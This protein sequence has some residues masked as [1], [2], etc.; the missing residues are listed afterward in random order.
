MRITSFTDRLK[1]MRPT[2]EGICISML[3]EMKIAA[4]YSKPVSWK[5]ISFC[6]II[7]QSLRW[8]S[9]TP[10]DNWGKNKIL[11][12]SWSDKGLLSVYKT[13]SPSLLTASI[14]KETVNIIPSRSNNERHNS[15]NTLRCYII[16]HQVPFSMMTLL[17]TISHPTAMHQSKS[18]KSEICYQL[19]SHHIGHS[20]LKC[21]FL[22]VQTSW[23]FHHR[24]SR[25]TSTEISP[26]IPA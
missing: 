13:Q 3:L 17:L 6:L 14:G 7:L 2:A 4:L 18:Y 20:L 26:G 25:A 22:D 9:L 15:V 10:T 16:R 19:K 21:P 24:K 5:V 1:D 12:F 11:Q 23:S 8:V